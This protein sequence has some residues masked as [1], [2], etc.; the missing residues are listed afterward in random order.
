M[1]PSIAIDGSAT[2]PLGRGQAKGR[3]VVAH[4]VLVIEI[5]PRPL[6]QVGSRPIEDVQGD[7]L[8]VL[9]AA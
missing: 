5:G 8:V 6:R 9:Y 4:T 1:E 2:I 7:S 3:V